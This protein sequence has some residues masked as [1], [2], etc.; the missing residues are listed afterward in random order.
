VDQHVRGRGRQHLPFETDEVLF[1][2]EEGTKGTKER[3]NGV[4]E[5]RKTE[6][7]GG[8][9]KTSMT[10]SERQRKGERRKVIG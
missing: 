8:S 1:L 4:K 9:E 5:E 7:R 2:T 3:I 10:G 6:I